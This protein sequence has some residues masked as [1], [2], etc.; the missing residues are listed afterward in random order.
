VLHTWPHL[1][2]FMAKSGQNTNTNPANQI[3][4]NP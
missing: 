1:A 2:S 4:Q 3:S